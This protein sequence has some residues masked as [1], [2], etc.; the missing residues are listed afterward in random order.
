MIR[1]SDLKR[2]LMLVDVIIVGSFGSIE[3]GVSLRDNGPGG[4][5]SNVVR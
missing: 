5:Y 4:V 2:I 1:E 3:P